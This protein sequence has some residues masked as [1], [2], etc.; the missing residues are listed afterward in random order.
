M[1]LVANASALLLLG[2]GLFAYTIKNSIPSLIG[3]T[4][5][6][7]IFAASSYFSYDGKAP[8]SNFVG[9]AGGSLTGLLGI[10]RYT[11]AK[12]KVAPSI[13]IAVG[14]ITTPYFLWM[15]FGSKSY[16]WN[17]LTGDDGFAEKEL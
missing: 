11:Q 15:A 3:S 9:A 7:S 8:A 12:K 6:A 13:L 10:I 16:P 4:A 14:C 5:L 2:G 17:F 1:S